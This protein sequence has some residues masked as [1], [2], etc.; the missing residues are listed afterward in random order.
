MR[1]DKPGPGNGWRPSSS[2]SMPRVRPTRRTSSLNS[3]RSG[4]ITFSFIKSGSPPTLWCDLMVAEGPFT[5]TDS[6]TSGYMVPCPSHFTSVSWCASSS[7]TS[8][9]TRPMVLRLVSGSSIP[10]SWERKRSEAST[11][12][13]FSPMSL[14]WCSTFANSSLRSKPLFTKIQYRLSPM[15]LFSNTAA[16]VESTPPERPST[17][18]SLPIFSFS[19]ATISSTN[20]DGVKLCATPAIFTRKFSSILVPSVLWYTSG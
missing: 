6:I 8:M 18:L 13:T 11:P 15:A 20:E 5:E 17:T 9:K 2:G 19:S 12:F 4:S 10:A 3:I 7:K 16:T 14:Y 1:I